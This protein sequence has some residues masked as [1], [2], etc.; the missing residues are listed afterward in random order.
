MCW[1]FFP[2]H[3]FPPCRR[4]R[5]YAASEKKRREPNAQHQPAVNTFRLAMIENM[6][7][8]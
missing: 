1:F 8:G 4:F 5:D 7:G 3:L 2:L 6:S